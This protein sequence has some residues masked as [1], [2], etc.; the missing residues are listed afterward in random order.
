MDLFTKVY[1]IL[2]RFCMDDRPEVRNAAVR[3]LCT[4]LV[5]YGSRMGSELWHS[6]VLESLF[7]VLDQ[8]SSNA[9]RSSDRESEATELGKERGR[10][11]RMMVHHSRNTEQK[12]WDETLSL[13]MGGLGRLLRAHMAALVAVDGFDSKWRSFLQLLASSLRTGRKEL[14]TSAVQSLL[15]V[16]QAYSG[17]RQQRQRR[18]Q[19]EGG[20]QQHQDREVESPAST[21]LW[22]CSMDALDQMVSACTVE[23]SG[24]S[25]VTSKWGVYDQGICYVATGL[26]YPVA[27]AA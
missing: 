13:L 9:A 5:T 2:L 12:Q 17:A 26:G 8:I 3:T 24:L 21:A 16:L 25:D 15:S 22:D 4:L 11:V 23:A 14:G 6:L 18:Q 20:M 19:E 7:P 27:S 1:L 10:T